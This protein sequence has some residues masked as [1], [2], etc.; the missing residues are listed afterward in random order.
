MHVSRGWLLLV[1][2]SNSWKSYGRDVFDELTDDL[3][4]GSREACRYQTMI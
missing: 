3:S 1:W 2:F 4:C